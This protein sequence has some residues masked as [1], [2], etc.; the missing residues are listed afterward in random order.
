LK[1][2]NKRQCLTD[3]TR[4][5]SSKFSNVLL[6]LLVKSRLNSSEHKRA[7]DCKPGRYKRICSEIEQDIPNVA[8][9]YS[10]SRF[11][12]RVVVIRVSTRKS[13]VLHRLRMML[14][15]HSHLTPEQHNLIL[16]AFTY[17]HPS[18]LLAA[19]NQTQRIENPISPCLDQCNHRVRHTAGAACTKS[20]IL[21]CSNPLTASCPQNDTTHSLTTPDGGNS[22]YDQ[23][24]TGRS[25]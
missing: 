23:H 17:S 7:G 5:R 3:V 6:S 18:S 10:R 24:R 19:K 1:R 11:T 13:I 15:T 9:I 22:Y 8:C 20:S 14:C 21:N 4:P 16:Q 25:C 2:P 12:Y